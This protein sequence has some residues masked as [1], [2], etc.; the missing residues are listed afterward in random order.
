MTEKHLCHRDRWAG[1]GLELVMVELDGPDGAKSREDSP[2]HL[3]QVVEGQVHIQ[4]TGQ[5]AKG[6]AS[7]ICQVVIVHVHVSTRGGMYSILKS[8][9]ET[10]T[11]NN[12]NR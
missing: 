6:A 11:K 2:P 3:G 1:Y 7:K 4:E 8:M 10:N 5:L 9:T 12:L